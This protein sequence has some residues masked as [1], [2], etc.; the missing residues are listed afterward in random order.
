MADRQRFSDRDLDE[1]GTEAARRKLEGLPGRC[2]ALIAEV[3][4]LRGLLDSVY[5]HVNE[6]PGIEQVLA[7]LEMEVTAIRAER[8]RRQAH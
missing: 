1:I 6:T 8:R 7:D 3:R 4:F 2:V 5:D